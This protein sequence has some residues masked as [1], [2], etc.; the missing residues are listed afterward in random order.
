MVF[1]QLR[2][3]AKKSAGA[4]WQKSRISTVTSSKDSAYAEYWTQEDDQNTQRHQYLSM[5]EKQQV[6][7]SELTIYSTPNDPVEQKF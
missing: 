2:G 5:I 4:S 6:K 1:H 7:Y 3:C